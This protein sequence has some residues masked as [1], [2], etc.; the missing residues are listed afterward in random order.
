MHL[1][2][3]FYLERGDLG[4]CGIIHLWN[5]LEDQMNKKVAEALAAAGPAKRI[6]SVIKPPTSTKVS[7]ET[8]PAALAGSSAVVHST[9]ADV[10]KTTMNAAM[11]PLKA[12]IDKVAAASCP[13]LQL[14]KVNYVQLTLTVAPTLRIDYEDTKGHKNFVVL[15]KRF[16]EDGGASSY[17]LEASLYSNTYVQVRNNLPEFKDWQIIELKFPTE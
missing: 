10:I 12:Q 5:Y 8:T 2:G 1:K 14:G 11:Q 13:G 17:Q 9:I 16:I 7:P 4:V 15:D 6:R 3:L